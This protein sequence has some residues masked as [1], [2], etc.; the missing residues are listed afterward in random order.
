MYF[1]FTL[2]QNTLHSSENIL[3]NAVFY[4]VIVTCL[5]VYLIFTHSKYVIKFHVPK[6]WTSV[7][8][9]CSHIQMYPNAACSVLPSQHIAII[10]TAQKCR[11]R[12]L[13]CLPAVFGHRPAALVALRR[14]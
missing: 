4:Y 8:G 7:T 3:Q 12:V 10:L 13:K 11:T 2:T 14:T 6:L 1:S 5:F 9:G